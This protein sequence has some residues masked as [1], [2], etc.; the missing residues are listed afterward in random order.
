MAAPI[1]AIAKVM[2]RSTSRAGI[3][4]CRAGPISCSSGTGERSRFLPQHDCDLGFTRGTPGGFHRASRLA[5]PARGPYNRPMLFALPFPAIDPVLIEIG[6]FAIRWYALAYVIGIILG[7]RYARSLAAKGASPLTPPML[8]DFVTWAVLG[9]VLGGRIGYVLFY[10]LQRYLET[11]V[12]IFAIWHGGMSF[13]GGLVGMILAMALFARHRG[14]RFFH[15]TDPIAAATPIGLFFGRLANFINGELYGRPTDVSWAI[16]FPR[17]PEG[18]PRHPSQLYEAG[19][20]GILLLILLYIA[21]QRFDA[22]RRPGLESGLFLCGYAVC[23]IVVELFREPDVQI[24][25]LLGGATMG[26]LLSL[27]MLVFGI[28]FIWQARRAT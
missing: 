20:E 4:R 16:I 9:I 11:P 18:L 26:Q 28:A 15:V 8:D 22:L 2:P 23:R 14:L 19:L 6:P 7:W 1:P 10:D 21:A 17:D 3:P 24:G 12:Q 13:H 27:P 5:A 25:F